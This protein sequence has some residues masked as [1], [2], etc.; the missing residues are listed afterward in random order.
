MTNLEKKQSNILEIMQQPDCNSAIEAL[1]N[2]TA[3]ITQL[4]EG[5]RFE[6]TALDEGMRIWDD[7]LFTVQNVERF[8]LSKE[9][10]HDELVS[11]LQNAKEHL[12]V[13]IK[14]VKKLNWT[15]LLAII[16]MEHSAL[17]EA[18]EIIKSRKS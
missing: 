14:T 10:S 8:I 13:R 9:L 7:T 11:C 16:G 1:A 4:L 12:E 15:L 3:G 17:V 6:R 2:E 18:I 5:I